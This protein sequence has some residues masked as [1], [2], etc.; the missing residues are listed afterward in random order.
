MTAPQAHTVRPDSK[1]RITLGPYAKGVSSFRIHPQK[2][3]RLVLEPYTEIPAREAWLFENQ[4]A[5]TK[6]RKGLKDAA[7]G[8]IS[9]RG[10]FSKFVDDETG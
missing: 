5:L 10:D 8:K 2:D 7:A 4:A 1:G 6:V 9:R 3:G